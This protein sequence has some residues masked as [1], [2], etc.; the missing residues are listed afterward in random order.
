M[1]RIRVRRPRIASFRQNSCGRH[2]VQCVQGGTTLTG[3]KFALASVAIS[4]LSMLSVS[5]NAI[6]VEFTSKQCQHCET[7]KPVLAQLERSGVAI[8]RVDVSSEPHLVR[9]YGVRQT[10]TYLVIA[11]GKEVTRLVGSHSIDELR[12]ALQT[13]PGG[14]HIPT[15]SQQSAAPPRAAEFADTPRTRLAAAGPGATNPPR[16]AAFGRSDVRPQNVPSVATAGNTMSETMPNVT[17]AD[18]VERARAATVRL[19][20]YDGHGF[21]VGTGTIIDSHGAESLV[22][23]CGHLFRDTD[24]EGRIEVDLFVGGETKTVPGQLVDYDA[25]D[26]DIAVVAIQPG[27]NIQPV[28]VIKHS[29]KV[30]TGQAAFSFGCDRGADPSRRDTRITGVDKYNQHLGVSNLEIDG[31]P[32]DGRSGGG[33]FDQNG[34]LIGVC[35]AADY[36]S[37]VGIYT[38]PGSIHWQLE[39]V[40]LTHLAQGDAGTAVAPTNQFS[41][42]VPAGGSPAAEPPVRLAALDAPAGGFDAGIV[43]PSALASPA[44]QDRREVIVIIRDPDQPDTQPRVLTIRQPSEAL[45]NS[46]MTH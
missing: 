8:R 12:Q 40:N 36:K 17:M 2:A 43:Q 6:L 27:I 28:K 3:I 16:L 5:A 7:M 44:G 38:G 35:N 29:Q 10:P 1:V 32:I 20:V 21:G 9:R 15:G 31:A 4:W 18:A 14:P 25:E 22:M 23:T 41:A 45:M 34:C 11:D 37:D 42:T 19:R 13:N 33:L 30:T 24:G 39:R 26:R 46:L